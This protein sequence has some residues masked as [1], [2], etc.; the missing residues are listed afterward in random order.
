MPLVM[1]VDDADAERAA[2]R[3][4]LERQGYETVEAA[5]GLDAIGLLDGLRPDLILLDLTMPDLDGLTLLRFIYDNPGWR[6]IPVVVVTGADDDEVLGEARRLGARECLF[7]GSA[8]VPV[9]L[10][11][12]KRHAGP[13]AP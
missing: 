12:V 6:A 5:D 3:R 2:A 8:S 13:A 4:L 10:D 11:A 7:K 1:L 9:V